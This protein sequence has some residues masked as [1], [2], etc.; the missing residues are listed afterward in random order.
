M[1]YMKHFSKIPF[2]NTETQPCWNGSTSPGNWLQREGFIYMNTWLP[3]MLGGG[4]NLYWLWRTYWAGAERAVA[5]P[6]VMVT[7]R[8][9]S[10]ASYEIVAA[11]NG[12]AGEY[13]FDGRRLDL[14]SDT[15]YEGK[16]ELSPY[17]VAVLEK[18][19]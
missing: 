19:A 17:Q 13:V 8:V 3:I 1:D 12:D 7:R 4:A 15:V 18:T 16:I 6:G 9:S 2:R 14:L 10:E 11:V 5:S